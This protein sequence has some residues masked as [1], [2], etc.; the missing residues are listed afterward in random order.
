M[1]DRDEGEAFV[2]NLGFNNES[3]STRPKYNPKKEKPS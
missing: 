2:E 3:E 1:D